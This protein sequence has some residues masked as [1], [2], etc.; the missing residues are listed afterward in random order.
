[1]TIYDKIEEI[2]RTEKV[3]QAVKVHDWETV[4]ETILPN[5]SE[6]DSGRMGKIY[7]IV[8]KLYLNGY[9]GNS[10]IVSSKGK[11][12]VIY[13]GKK[14]EVKS[15]C[16]E[17]DDILKRNCDGVIYTMSNKEMVFTPENGRVF[18]ADDFIETIEVLDLV[19]EKRSS[20]GYM[21]TTI[22]SYANSK[23]KATRL[24]NALSERPTLEEWIE[25]L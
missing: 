13:K 2:L 9:R 25:S 7:E 15:N 18:T 19:R 3:R 21:R 14:M 11:V 6:K 17:L 4:V 12:D 16:G 23:K 20:S 22:Q 5:F 10:C 24:A 8:T 1:M